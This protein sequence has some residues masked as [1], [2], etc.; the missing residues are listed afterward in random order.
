MKLT[1]QL[2]SFPK[3]CRD[4]SVCEAEFPAVFGAE[5]M[6]GKSRKLSSHRVLSSF[7][8]CTSSAVLVPFLSNSI[9]STSRRCTVLSAKTCHKVQL[10]P[11][12]IISVIP[13]MAFRER[14]RHT[15]IFQICIHGYHPALSNLFIIGTGASN[16]S[17][18]SSFLKKT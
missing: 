17:P 1:A 16:N 14:R 15:K 12:A 2:S 7:A 13:N 18:K 4:P 8:G 3:H 5:K 11:T 10:N 9:G 6:A